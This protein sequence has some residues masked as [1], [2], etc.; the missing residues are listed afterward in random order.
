MTDVL[1][2]YQSGKLWDFHGGIHPPEMKSQSN[3]TPI[4]TAPLTEKFYV[5]VK[6][7]SG[8][9]GSLLVKVGDTVLKGQ[10]LTQGDGL[11]C[12]PVHAPTSGIVTDIAPYIAAHP[13]GLSELAVHIQADGKDQW[14]EQRPIDDF[15]TQPPRTINSKNLS[16][17][18]SRL[19]RCSVPD[20]GKSE[21]GSFYPK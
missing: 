1:S 11:R 20:S 13:S 12:L 3:S 8:T 21:F 5:P 19:R 14:R 17:G 2:R 7:H 6:Q 4:S 10:P 9:A 18:C 15:L 16:G